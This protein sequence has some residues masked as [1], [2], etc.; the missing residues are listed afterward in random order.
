MPAPSP[1]ARS[2]IVVVG[3]LLVAWAGAAGAAPCSAA[4]R[5][6]GDDPLSRE[7]AYA[8]VINGLEREA[9]AGCPLVRV[10]VERAGGAIRVALSDRTGERAE[11]VVGEVRTAAAV[12]ASW[13]EGILASA[14]PPAIGGPEL[15]AAAGREQRRPLGGVSLLYEGGFDRQDQ[16]W[17]SKA[18]A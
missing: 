14:A 15:V 17:S 16:R 7:V 8:L 18:L 10:R 2:S 13:T 9:P 5:V 6:V 1:R 4:A 12:V 3:G 11:R